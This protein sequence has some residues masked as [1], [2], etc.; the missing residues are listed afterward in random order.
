MHRR[1][2]SDLLSYLPAKALPAVTPFITVPIFTRQF[3]PDQYGDYM[4]A[5][6]VA[7][8][9]LAATCSGFAAG[10][11]RFYAAYDRAADLPGY[12]AALLT[13]ITVVIV[14]ASSLTA[15][16]LALGRGAIAPNLYPLLWVALLTFMVNAWYTGLVHVLRA[17][18][19]SRWY[20]A[21]EIAS[22]Y[23]TVILSLVLIFGFGAGVEALLW[24]Q[25]L[26]LLIAAGPLY[27]LATRGLSVRVLAP[28]PDA[29]RRMWRYALPLTAGNIA[30]W[31]LRLA[32]RYIIQGFRST[33]E[34]GLYSV[35]Y[36]LSARSIDLVVGLFFLVPGPIIMRLWEEQGR[37][38]AEEALAS[39]TRLFFML[40]VPAVAGLA[41]TAAPLVR[42][43]ADAAYFDGHR[44]IWL[45]ACASM[46]F[47]LGQLG[48]F[49][50]LL[51][52]KT[53]LVARN[54]F[55]VTGLSVGLNILTVPIWG[56][57]GAALSAAVSFTL[58]AGLQSACSARYLTWRWP[59]K[60][61]L[62]VVAAAVTMA[63]VVALFLEAFGGYDAR[64]S[65]GT[66][67]LVCLTAVIIGMVSYGF[68]LV[69]LG[70]FSLKSVARRASS[71][72][73]A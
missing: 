10:A 2:V 71:G 13:S 57:M 50:L 21:F 45:V 70:E 7:E 47:G 19:R 28:P 14:A 65:S 36:N 51:E 34:V 52:N 43:L 35:S 39:I 72:T 29:V 23:G 33:Y 68:I 53:G 61:F 37:V 16:G 55:L 44:A 32:D 25:F 8:L 41:V 54:Q 59:V 49:G 11:V 64:T 1:I 40:I 5:F 38:A 60:S 24:G 48:S 3:S 63:G 62:H 30:F 73:S 67:V 31:S 56:F 46:A 18:E 9:L 66:L 17:Q 15:L 12:F 27:W 4:L 22:R 58:L 69:A 20:T 26:A 42:L 6:G